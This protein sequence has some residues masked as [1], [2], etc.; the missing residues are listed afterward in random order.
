M[1]RA[2]VWAALLLIPLASIVSGQSPD[3]KQFAAKAEELAKDKN[4]VGAIELMKKASALEPKND[5]YLAMTGEYEYKSGKFADGLEHAAAAIKL[6]DK[7]GA[8]FVIAAAN[9]YGNQDLERAR[10]YC[11]QVLSKGPQVFGPRNCF[12]AQGL[13]DAMAV[14]EYT[15]YWNLDPKKGKMANGA[16]AVSLPKNGVPFQSVKYEIS[17]V[18]SSKFLKGDVNDTLSVVPQGTKPFP[19]TIKVTTTPYSYKKDLAKAIASQPVPAPA[20]AF[21]GPFFMV[22]PKSVTLKKVAKEVKTDDGL[23]TVRNILAW[24]KKNIDYKLQQN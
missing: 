6:N 7:N 3:A 8:Y 15:L 20:K 24:M 11:E 23:S 16:F 4:Y 13:S 10:E 18:K 9:A 22:D 14:K 5:V 19:L 12:D 17:D 2:K 21:L 1:H